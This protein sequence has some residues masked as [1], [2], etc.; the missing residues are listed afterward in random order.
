MLEDSRGTKTLS[1]EE[2]IPHLPSPLE[3]DGNDHSIY[4]LMHNTLF[5][6]LSAHSDFPVLGLSQHIAQ[7]VLYVGRRI[8]Y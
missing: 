5:S 6:L 3:V 1:F 2:W 4:F 7:C 8:C